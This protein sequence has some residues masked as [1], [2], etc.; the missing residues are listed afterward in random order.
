[1]QPRTGKRV[2]LICED[3]SLTQQHFK[4]LVDPKMIMERYLKTGLVDPSV[5][6]SANAAIYGDASELPDS[7][8]KALEVI[9]GAAEGFDS[10]PTRV[11]ER[12]GSASE[13]VR[14]TS[15]DRGMTDL[16]DILKVEANERAASLAG[17]AGQAAAVEPAANA[18]GGSTI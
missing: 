17:K 12:Y 3:P 13:F 4:D 10:L 11:K 1:M 2:Q 5:V 16:V 9:R 8:E 14:Q 18:E 7:Y 6:R 15:D